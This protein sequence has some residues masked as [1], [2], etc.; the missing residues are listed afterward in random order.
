MHFTRSFSNLAE[1]HSK[2]IPI[3]A[4]AEERR[5]PR[6]LAAFHAG[7]SS[8]GRERFFVWAGGKMQVQSNSSDWN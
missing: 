2:L 1:L 5:G 8:R 6:R 4:A 7:F 3:S